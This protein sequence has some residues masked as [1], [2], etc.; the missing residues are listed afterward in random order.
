MK[1]I[2]KTLKIDR[3]VVTS[4]DLKKWETEVAQNDV[5]LKV[6]I[7]L[8]TVVISLSVYHLSYL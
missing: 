2:L 8:F 5:L 6:A 4:S 1:T 3:A 7:S